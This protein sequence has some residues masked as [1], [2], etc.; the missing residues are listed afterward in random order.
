MRASIASRESSSL[1]LMNTIL[2]LMDTVTT[3]PL[4]SLHRSLPLYTSCS[5]ALH[6]TLSCAM[7][8]P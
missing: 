1:S 3:S 7:I 8:T 6:A 4:T 5:I 2:F